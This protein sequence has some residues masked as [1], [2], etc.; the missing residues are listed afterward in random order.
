L[1]QPGDYQEL[2]VERRTL[3][4]A[5]A[6]DAKLASQIDAALSSLLVE[7]KAVMAY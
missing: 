1:L 2:R 4:L 3:T 5:H 6:G 7:L